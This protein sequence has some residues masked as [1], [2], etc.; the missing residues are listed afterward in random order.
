MKNSIFENAKIKGFNN[1]KIMQQFEKDYKEE[2]YDWWLDVF[3]NILDFFR[4]ISTKNKKNLILF[5]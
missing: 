1:D 5:F 3:I 4:K 2:F